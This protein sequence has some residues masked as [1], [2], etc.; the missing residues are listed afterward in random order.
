MDQAMTAAVPKKPSLYQLLGEEAGIRA[1]VETFYD[2]VEHDPEARDL[3]DLHLRGFGLGHSRREQFDYLCGFFGGQQ[4]YV[5]R[6]GHARLREIH[7]HVAIG[8]D[9]RDL[10]LKCMAKA[11]DR[12]ALPQDLAASMMRHFS[13]AAEASRNRD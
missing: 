1:L 9:M 8:R 6:H 4:Y 2:I 10:W 5:M 13:V 3:H 7:A 12:L 11:I